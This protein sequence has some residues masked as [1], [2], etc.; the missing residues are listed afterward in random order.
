MLDIITRKTGASIAFA[1]AAIAAMS[2]RAD[3]AQGP[4]VQAVTSNQTGIWLRTSIDQSVRLRFHGPDAVMQ[5]SPAVSTSLA[6]ADDTASFLLT[7][8]SPGSTYGYEVGTT[9]P[10]SGVETWTGTYTF[11]TVKDRV[12]VLRIAVLSDFRNQMVA[13][14]A[15][16]TALDRRPDVLAVIGDLDHRDPASAPDGN[17][18]PPEDAPQVLADMRR[19]HRDSRDPATPLGANFSSGIVGAPDTGVAQIPMVYAWDDHDFCSNNAG[20]SCPFSTQAFQ[21]YNEY[22]ILSPD[23][24]YAAGCRMPG[25]FESLT[26]GK[27]VQV[28]FLDAR[29]DR[30]DTDPSGK[31]AMLG[32]CQHKWLV[33]GLHHSKALWKI[34]M[35]PV[36]FNPTMKTWDAWSLFGSER[37][38]LLAAIAD[39]PNVVFVSGDVHSGGAVDDGEHSG[40]PEVSTPHANMPDDWVNTFC[41]AQNGTLISRPGSWTIGAAVDPNIGVKPMNCLSRTFRDDYPVDGI[42]ASVYPLDGHGNPGFTWIEASRKSLIVNVHGTNGEV[43]EGVKADGS[44]ALLE[45]R[46]SPI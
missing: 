7:G 1:C 43:K 25:D 12:D 23:N 20:R 42:P 16:Q 46:L 32:A 40:R 37:A 44:P 3:V 36:P 18:Y 30:N 45:L 21:A 5:T 4:M 33:D 13:S 39:V 35:S 24:A 41:R 27:L 28:F 17:I 11:E 34:V 38:S 15:L 9:D 29:S 10:V 8:L 6:N 22:Y 26:F 14:E 31:T 2:V 19:M